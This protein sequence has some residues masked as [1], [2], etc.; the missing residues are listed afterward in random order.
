MVIL[1]SEV[2][3]KAK[4]GI[5]SHHWGTRLGEVDVFKGTFAASRFAEL[6]LAF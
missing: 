1:V 2:V 3:V 4:Q 5:I 6:Y